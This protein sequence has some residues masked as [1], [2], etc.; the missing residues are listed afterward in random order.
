MIIKNIKNDVWKT[1]QKYK[2]CD[3]KKEMKMEIKKM[4]QNKNRMPNIID[5]DKAQA[6]HLS[7]CLK[8]GDKKSERGIIEA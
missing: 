5:S 1:T 4:Y 2:I 3:H 6:T 8:M 7:E